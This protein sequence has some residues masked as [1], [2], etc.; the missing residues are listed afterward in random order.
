MSTGLIKSWSYSRLA[1]FE[2]CA[3]RAK[4]KIIDKIPEPDRPLKPGQTEHANDRG[5]RIHEAIEAFIRGKGP[6]PVEADKFKPAIESLKTRFAAGAVSL[7]GEWGFDRDW[8]PC[9]YNDRK[10]VWLRVK[11]DAS[12]LL[13]QKHLLVVDYKSGRRDGNEIKHGEQTMLYGLTAAIRH[14]KVTHIDTELWYIDQKPGF[15]I[16]DESRPVSRWL[17][18]LKMFNNRGLKMT[19]ATEFKPNPSSYACKW[20]PY[21]EGACQ[22]A[23]V[24]GKPVRRKGQ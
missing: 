24:E 23:Y 1:D 11:L 14:P 12:V 21:K 3:Y 22:F 13:T 5:T 7:E 4:L 15:N 18:H 10:K 17:Y 19:N 16:A 20:C 9:D 6:F 8:V 2:T